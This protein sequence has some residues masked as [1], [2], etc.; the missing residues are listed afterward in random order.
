ML[1]TEYYDFNE[2]P[3]KVA[4]FLGSRVQVQGDVIL[5]MAQLFPNLAALA[6]VRNSDTGLWSYQQELVLESAVSDFAVYDDTIVLT[7]TSEDVA[8]FSEAGAAHVFYPNTNAYFVLSASE[9]E[10]KKSVSSKSARNRNG[11]HLASSVSSNGRHN[12]GGH[13]KLVNL[14]PKS[15][16]WSQQQVLHSPSPSNSNNFGSDVSL[17]KNH[18]VIGEQGTSTVYLFNRPGVL[19]SAWSQVQVLKATAE[20]VEYFSRSFF[21]G[22]S[23]AVAGI[24]GT[25][26][27]LETFTSSADWKCLVIHV[28][29]SF[30]DGWGSSQL[31]VQT[32]VGG[33]FDYFSP[34]CNYPNPFTFRYCPLYPEDGGT[35]TFSVPEGTL[36]QYY[37]EIHFQ[38][39]EENSKTWFHGDSSTE[40]SFDFDSTELSFSF[41]EGRNVLPVVDSCQVCPVTS[42][43]DSWAYLEVLMTSEEGHSWFQDSYRGTSYS[44]SDAEGRRE[45]VAGRMCNPSPSEGKTN[46]SCWHV[47]VDGQYTFR[48]SDD[49]NDRQGGEAMSWSF[50][51][52][53]GT[54]NVHMFFEISG[55]HCTV[56]AMYSLE[57]YCNSQLNAQSVVAITVDMFN[58]S[59]SFT[60]FDR[61][62]FS[63]TLASFVSFLDPRDVQF[64]K[65]SSSAAL[66]DSSLNVTTVSLNLIINAA[67]GGADPRSLS[68]MRSMTSAVVTSMEQEMAPG[69]GFFSHL[70]LSSSYNSTHFLHMT[71]LS[72]VTIAVQDSID[73]IVPTQL[74]PYATVVT[75]D[76][77]SFINEA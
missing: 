61:A 21:H 74:H 27:H 58:T 8:G 10:S 50:C 26:T 33:A 47:L 53:T 69:G 36:S 35:Y 2:H 30:G 48:V 76:G 52:S 37:W 45:L 5:G 63:T 14:F 44:I 20:G 46:Y 15:T 3:D 34:V 19:G 6:F 18:L 70:K 73:I 16:Q 11:V 17:Q 29:D 40:V 32:P 41:L 12:G 66:A 49:L 57:S 54:E 68:S 4:F 67:K 75:A 39:Y 22:T 51:N 60:A 1:S 31:Q 71:S 55:G 43:F 9:D 23:L 13:R 56:V 59:G 62:D 7:S 25:Q 24:I 64:V 38:I 77:N 72:L 42:P 65:V 28:M